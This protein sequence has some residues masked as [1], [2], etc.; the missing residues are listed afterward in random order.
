MLGEGCPALGR[1]AG[2]RGDCHGLEE[3]R[4]RAIDGLPSPVDREPCD[5][6]VL[7]NEDD[8]PGLH[9]RDVTFPP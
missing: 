3:A 2:L 8:R 6:S 1:L 5:G 9:R 7:L 4:T